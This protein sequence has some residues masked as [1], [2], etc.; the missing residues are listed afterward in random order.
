MD[1]VF[2]AHGTRATEEETNALLALLLSDKVKITSLARFTIAF[3]TPLT[4]K[5][6]V[7]D[8]NLSEAQTEL[9][10]HAEQSAVVWTVWNHFYRAL[11]PPVDHHG[12]RATT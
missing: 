6:F 7:T 11:V 12:P 8:W 4:V 2:T 9:L 5:A 1:N 3:N 10:T